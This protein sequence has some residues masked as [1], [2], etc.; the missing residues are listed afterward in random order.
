MPEFMW[1]QSIALCHSV[2]PA[3]QR[4]V[5]DAL[6]RLH[7]I[8]LPIDPRACW[9][10]VGNRP[11]APKRRHDRRVWVSVST[12]SPIFLPSR[13]FALKGQPSSSPGQRPGWRPAPIHRSPE[14]AAL[15]RVHLQLVPTELGPG[16]DTPF[17][18][19]CSQQVLQCR[20]GATLGR[21]PMR[22]FD[23][24]R[25]DLQCC[26]LKKMLEGSNWLTIAPQ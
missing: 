12:S 14:G 21:A 20:F 24:K 26:R 18:A 5:P 8:E 7:G 13:S 2:F 1:R 3:S 11:K 19:H 16:L 25:E 4:K 9:K 23:R 6:Y 22:F 15:G 17:N 10:V